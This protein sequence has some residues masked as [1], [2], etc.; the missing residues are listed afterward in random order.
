MTIQSLFTKLTSPNQKR[1]AYGIYWG[2]NKMNKIGTQAT[3]YDGI[4]TF[5]QWVSFTD[6]DFI[7]TKLDGFSVVGRKTYESVCNIGGLRICVK[8]YFGMINRN[9][10]IDIEV[11]DIEK[12]KKDAEEKQKIEN[13]NKELIKKVNLH[14]INFIRENKDCTD[15]QYNS[16]LSK[17]D[18]KHI[19]LFLS[20]VQH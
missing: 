2:I 17:F 12:I 4:C 16:E 11:I 1:V 13:E 6:A 14:M 5:S 19:K 15:E 18:E 20:Q 10:K 9:A 3:T 7:I 8:Y